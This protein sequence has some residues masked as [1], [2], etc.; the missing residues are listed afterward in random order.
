MSLDQIML[1]P[2]FDAAYGST[3]PTITSSAAPSVAENTTAVL[4]VTATGGQTPYTFSISGGADAA[5]FSINSSTGALAFL[6]APDYEA[7]G[8]AGANNVY[9]VTVKVESVGGAFAEQ[10]VVVTVTNVFEPSDIPGLLMDFDADAADRVYSD[11]GSTLA[12]VGD[13]VYRVYLDVAKTIYVEQSNSSLQYTLRA[14]A[15]GKRY[16]EGSGSQRMTGTVAFASFLRHMVISSIY[17]NSFVDNTFFYFHNGSGANVLNASNQASGGNHTR[18]DYN[19][20][21][22]GTSSTSDTAAPTAT[23]ETIAHRIDATDISAIRNGTV[24][25]TTALTG[26][27]ACDLTGLRIGGWLSAGFEANFN[28]QRQ[29]L[30]ANEPTT[31]EQA[32]LQTYLA[33]NFPT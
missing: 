10:N 11:A 2:G 12:N 32:D 14:G 8:D 17:R 13:K 31:Q 21:G 29:L 25:G 27:N 5:L 1:V 28:I 24:E 9:N 15:N 7:P 26:I 19:G 22:G 16:F 18:H 33:A 6:V 20:S 30:Y 23:W 4:T 3:P